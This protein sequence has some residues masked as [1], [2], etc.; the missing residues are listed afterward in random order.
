MMLGGMSR[1]KIVLPNY[2]VSMNPQTAP[3]IASLGI[4]TRYAGTV[5]PG[6][7][8]WLEVQ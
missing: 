1:F 7:S 5:N 8:F 3:L 6:L 2:F 4:P